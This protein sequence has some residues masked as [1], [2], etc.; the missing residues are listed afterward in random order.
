MKEKISITI[1]GEIIKLL[2]TKIKQNSEF[3]NQSHFVE[4]AIIEK[5]DVMWCPRCEAYVNGNHECFGGSK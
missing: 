4:V 3:R 1:D 5:L 2:Q